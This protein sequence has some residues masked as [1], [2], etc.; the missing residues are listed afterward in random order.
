MRFYESAV[1]FLCT[2]GYGISSSFSCLVD[3]FVDHKVGTSLCTVV[4]G[5]GIS[6]LYIWTSRTV[7]F[8]ESE[9][10]G[11]FPNR[12]SLSAKKQ[13]SS[14]WHFKYAFQD[15]VSGSIERRCPSLLGGSDVILDGKLA[16]RSNHPGKAPTFS[17][18]T[19][20]KV[21][22]CHGNVLFEMRAGKG[23]EL[24]KGIT[25]KVRLPWRALPL[26]LS[27]H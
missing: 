25:R 7:A 24:V 16:A 10:C 5:V 27:L 9:P 13:L 11:V 21:E 23:Q 17:S 2:A 18:V 14:L 19:K 26:P 4:L 8:P 6:E 15:G 3:Q 12:T 22:D 20:V 1:G